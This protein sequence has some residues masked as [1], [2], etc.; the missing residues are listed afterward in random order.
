MI[1]LVACDIDG[2]LL[3]R[4][5]SAIA[6]GIFGEIR[7]LRR[8]GVA[9]CPA[10]GRQ[11]T[12]LRRLFA[13]VADELT[14]MC[15]NGAVIF[16]P[17]SPGRAIAKVEM[18]RAAAVRLAEEIVA[19]PGCEVQIS[20]EDRSYLC[21]KGGEIVTIMRDIVG[22]NVTIVPSPADVPEPIV[23]VAAYN[24]AGAD[25]LRDMFDARWRGVFRTAVSGDCWFDFNS[26]DKGGGLR[27]LCAS[28]GV[29]LEEAA[30]IGDSWNDVPMLDA[31]GAPFIM[32][33]AEPALRARY[34]NTCRRVEET[35]RQLV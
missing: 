34:K 15:E 23:K 21:P 17:G 13:P 19:A 5:A 2:T 28:L 18:E 12:S 11:Y 14:Y 8:L 4:G 1:K 29:K 9:F 7:R 31:A 16:G 30:A 32:Q 22:N 24:P 33:N 3:P 25:V 35:L 20:G 27:R 26:T 6:P 10:S